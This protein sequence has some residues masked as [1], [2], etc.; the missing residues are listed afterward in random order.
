MKISIIQGS[1]RPNS[2][3]REVSEYL[4]S[5]LTALGIES[6]IVDLHEQRLPLFDA[7]EEGE[8]TQVWDSISRGLTESDGFIFVS[9][10]WD[11]MMSVGL[12]NFLHYTEKE[13]ADKPVLA[14]GV[15]SGRGGRYPLQQMRIMGY[16]NKSFVVIPES[17]FYDLIKQTLVDGA[18]TDPRSVE[19]TDYVLKTLV[20]YAKALTLVRASGVI[21]YEKF[22]NGL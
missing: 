15:S 1:T 5:R 20:E 14:V 10:E 16:K 7:S 4:S 21:D 9:P 17:L 13:L 19:R 11:G 8:W 22:P 18:L 6:S 2:A 3:S 12:H